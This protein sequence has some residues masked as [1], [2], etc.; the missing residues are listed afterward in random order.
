MSHG[1]QAGVRV[2]SGGAQVSVACICHSKLAALH[3]QRRRPPDIPL[4][5]PPPRRRTSCRR[6]RG[7]CASRTRAST[8]RWGAQG[9]PCAG[10]GLGWAPLRPRAPFSSGRRLPLLLLLA[11]RHAGLCL[12]PAPSPPRRVASPSRWCPCP[13][14]SRA[15]AARASWSTPWTARGTSTSTTRWGGLGSPGC[16][17]ERLLVNVMDCQGQ[18]LNDTHPHTRRSRPPCAWLM[19]CCWS[20]T[21]RR[22]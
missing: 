18:V 1:L 11:C 6:A 4:L 16:G 20:S 13:S 5:A 10:V 12:S 3:V 15:A 14:C 22:A 21:P 2:C 7:R 17:G 19:A 8:S 9:E